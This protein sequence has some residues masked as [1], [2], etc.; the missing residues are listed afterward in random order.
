M[1]VMGRSVTED[2][3]RDKLH[4][5][6]SRAFGAI[7]IASSAGGLLALS[8]VLGALPA[9]CWGSKSFSP[10][11]SCEVEAINARLS[12]AEAESSPL[13]L[14]QGPFDSVPL[15]RRFFIWRIKNP[16]WLDKS[17]VG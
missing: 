14:F 3:R 7:T 11:C 12:L 9:D 10:C 1:D 13:S 5:G 15:W 2:Q 8:E 4:K 17:G 16:I 6:S